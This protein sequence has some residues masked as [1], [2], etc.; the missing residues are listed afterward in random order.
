MLP[1]WTVDIDDVTWNRGVHSSVQLLSMLCMFFTIV[2][3]YVIYVKC[4]H[5]FWGMRLIKIRKSLLS[6]NLFSI[7]VTFFH[8]FPVC[9]IACHSELIYGII[10]IIVHNTVLYC[11]KETQAH[12]H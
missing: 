8:F 7:Q 9:K 1:I 2:L 10:L 12:Y 5:D 3:S 6:V 11:R 4:P